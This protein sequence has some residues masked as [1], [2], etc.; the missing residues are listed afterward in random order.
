M[1]T[2]TVG[3][4]GQPTMVQ[5][6]ASP[7]TAQAHMH[8]QQAQ[9]LAAHAA[10]AGVPTHAVLTAHAPAAQDMGEGT[11]L[12][13]T[14]QFSQYPTAPDIYVIVCGQGKTYIYDGVQ[15][16]KFEAVLMLLHEESRSYLT[17]SY[18]QMATPMS[19]LG[20][21]MGYPH[22]KNSNERQMSLNRFREKRKE[23]TYEKKIRYSVRKEVAEKSWS[24]TER[25]Q[26][27]NVCAVQMNRNKGQFAPSKGDEDGGNRLNGENGGASSA[28]THCGLEEKYTPM[29]R[30]GPEGPRTLC[31]ACGLMWA[32]KGCLRDLSKGSGKGSRGAPVQDVEMAAG[33]E[34]EYT[35]VGEPVGAV[36]VPA[37]GERVVHEMIQEEEEELEAQQAA[38]EAEE[39]QMK[40]ENGD[41]SP[42]E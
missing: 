29:M 4:P 16:H 7:G 13:V 32:N 11:Q 10:A 23:R 27:H 42:A 35:V 41:D 14:Y 3:Y 12:T 25:F 1:T 6:I 21:K 36:V 24:Q 15:P 17:A 40:E 19:A 9:V 22:R 28:C 31:N 37:D 33:P 5:A 8:H 30:K 2:V 38:E 34:N 26:L 39:E 18:P 20:P